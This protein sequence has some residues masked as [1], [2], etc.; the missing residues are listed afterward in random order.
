MEY[1]HNVHNWDQ[2]YN[3]VIMSMHYSWATPGRSCNE[4]VKELI[5]LLDTSK[6]DNQKLITER[7]KYG[8]NVVQSA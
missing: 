3:F 1:H 8:F 6:E 4:Y 7:T 2:R 5:T